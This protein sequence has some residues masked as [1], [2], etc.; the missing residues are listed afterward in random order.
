MCERTFKT[1]IDCN[2]NVANHSRE[3]PPLDPSPPLGE[4]AR[5]HYES[6]EI[7]PDSLDLAGWGSH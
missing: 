3:D 4:G 5:I 1:L 6:S 2:E 7:S